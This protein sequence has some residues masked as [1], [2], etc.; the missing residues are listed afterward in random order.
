M[1]A[2]KSRSRSSSASSSASRQRG[3]SAAGTRGKSGSSSSSSTGVARDAAPKITR[4][5]EAIRQ[6]AEA[7]GGR[8]ACVRGTEGGDSCLLRID[9]PGG[10]GE[11]RLKPIDWD[12]FFDIFDRQGL[13]FLYQ[14]RTKGGRISRFN[15]FVDPETARQLRARARSGGGGRDAR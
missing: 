7:R 15:K 9:F 12:T 5:H 11:D 1:A 10:A 6:W 14:D 4:D 3:R 2:S 13:V 8:P